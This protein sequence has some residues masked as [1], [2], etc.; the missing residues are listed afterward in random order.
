MSTVGRVASPEASSADVARC[1]TRR[2]PAGRSDLELA[3]TQEMSSLAVRAVQ[4]TDRGYD[5]MR[6]VLR[7]GVN[8]SL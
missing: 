7:F 1:P 6:G 2:H 3:P 5:I 4:I 8:W